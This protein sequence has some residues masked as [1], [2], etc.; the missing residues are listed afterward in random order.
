MPSR[1]FEWHDHIA[2]VEAEYRVSRI[3]FDRLVAQHRADPALQRQLAETRVNLSVAGR[4]LEGTYFV[5]LFAAFEAA[6][7]SYDRARHND[8]DRTQKAAVLIDEIGGRRGQGIPPAVRAGARA[9]C[10]VRNYWAHVG[11]EPPA[12]MSLIDARSRLQRYL[13]GLPDEWG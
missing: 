1:R 4:R 12:L 8:P 6:L 10:R 11:D 9:A 7:R 2:A 3:A 5:R 13:A